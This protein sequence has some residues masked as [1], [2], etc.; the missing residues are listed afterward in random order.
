MNEEELK[1]AIYT[2]PF[3]PKRLRLTNGET[4]EIRWLGAERICEVHLKD[5]PNYLG[6]GKID[7]PA[8]VDALSDVGF[9]EWAQLETTCPSG[10]VEKDMATNL[11]YIRGVI[12]QRNA[13]A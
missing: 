13:K 4:Y 8:V 6:Q 2:P 5:N 12:A 10:S 9:A 7:F 1:V 11:A 3:E